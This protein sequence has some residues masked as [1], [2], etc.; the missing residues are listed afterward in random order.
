MSEEL[1]GNLGFGIVAGVVVVAL[2]STWFFFHPNSPWFTRWEYLV[3]FPQVS[4]L[5]PGDPVQVNGIRR[6]KVKKIELQEQ[7]VLVTVSVLASVEVPT[8]SRF[9][10]VNAG[11]LGKREVEIRLG[12]SKE[13]LASGDRVRGG[14]DM[15]STRLAIVGVTALQAADSLMDIAKASLDSTIFHPRTAESLQ[16]LQQG[17]NRIVATL[18]RDVRSWLWALDSIKTELSTMQNQVTA[19]RDTIV[20]GTQVLKDH[21]DSI[22]VGLKILGERAESLQRGVQQISE[23]FVSDTTAVGLV[24]NPAFATRIDSTLSLSRTL[25]ADLRKKGLDLNV[26]IW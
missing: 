4:T 9:R 6:G 8:D 2:A 11:F 19:M 24:L 23:N 16:N 22:Y 5:S 17:K 3:E 7:S 25:L 10:V 26:D 21:L 15:G 1:G 18:R 13:I 12:E 20:P 14:Y